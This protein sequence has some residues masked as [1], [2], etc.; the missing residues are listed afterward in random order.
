MNSNAF[1]VIDLKATGRNIRRLRIESGLSVSAV[2]QFFG[3]VEPR[4]IY[5]WQKGESLPTVDNLFALGALFGV[6]MDHI[7][8]PMRG[9]NEQ[10]DSSC[11]SNHFMGFFIKRSAA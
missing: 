3:F 7:L 4:A 10:Q 1:P 6:P 5:K 2:Q 9:N 8:I 11:C